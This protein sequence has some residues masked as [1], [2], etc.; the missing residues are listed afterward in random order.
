[1]LGDRCSS[2]SSNPLV[3]KKENS[4]KYLLDILCYWHPTGGSNPPRTEL[5]LFNF[6]QSRRFLTKFDKGSN[7]IRSSNL[8]NSIINRFMS[9]F[10][11]PLT[12]FLQHP[13]NI[14]SSNQNHPLQ[15]PKILKEINKRHSK[16]TMSNVDLKPCL[17]HQN[18]VSF[19]PQRRTPVATCH[20]FYQKANI[21]SSASQ[22]LKPPPPSPGPNPSSPSHFSFFSL[23][24]PQQAL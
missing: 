17:P 4:S 14:L 21:S 20:I 11:I 7:H 22:P 1:M 16:L 9:C 2:I 19:P 6:I 13:R 12:T 3:P 8:P 24:H 18:L 10:Y 15:K 5:E 23:P